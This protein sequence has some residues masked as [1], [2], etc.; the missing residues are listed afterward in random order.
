[1]SACDPTPTDAWPPGLTA[2]RLATPAQAAVELAAAV[3]EDLRAALKA[4]GK[5][6]LAVSGGTTPADFLRR[7]GDQPLDWAR[8]QVTLTDERWV[9]AGHPR[10]NATLVATTLLAGAARACRWQ[11]LYCDEMTWAAGV[12]E[13]NTRLRSFGW[14]LDVAVLG[15]GEDGHVASLFPGEAWDAQNPAAAVVAASS[16][17]G[18]ERVSLTLRTLLSAAA[19]YLLIHGPRKE[20][21]LRT[22]A[23]SALP[24]SALLAGARSPVRAFIAEGRPS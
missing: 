10:A 11:P 12:Q 1:M 20:A 19:R 24:I 14:P 23:T 16:P 18:E 7:L 5:A 17:S 21:I 8:V 13:L 9:P 15:M 22:A 3:A 4:R 2:R 6:S